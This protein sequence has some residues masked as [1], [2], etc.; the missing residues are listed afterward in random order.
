MPRYRLD[1]AYDGSA[2]QGWQKQ[3]EAP[4]VQGEIERVLRMLLNDEAITIMGSG[5]TDTG[6]N[7]RGQVAHTDLPWDASTAQLRHKLNRLL[8]DDIRIT[9]VNRVDAGFHARFDARSRTYRYHLSPEFDPMRPHEWVVGRLDPD[10]MRGVAGG[11]LGTHD[12]KPWAA[13]TPGLAST[14]CTVT[15]CEVI[16]AEDGRI[17]VV[18]TA[19]R[20]LRNMV[21]RMVA[22]M[23]KAGRGG[24]ATPVVA[25]AK[26]LV[27]ERVS[28]EK[29]A[30]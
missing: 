25:P 24:A 27:L 7:A 5:R 6:V 28:Y 29:K 19:D 3:A 23:V 20:F 11:F 4:T 17:H 26:A 18:V 10:A 30:G 2:Y 22:A 9:D 1:I 12:F 16:T 21:R 13:S 15:V 8:P 14:V